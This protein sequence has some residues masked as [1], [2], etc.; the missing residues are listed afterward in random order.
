MWACLNLSFMA[1]LQ[2]DFRWLITEPSLID[3][4]PGCP[5]LPSYIS[6]RFR[7][8]YSCQSSHSIPPHCAKERSWPPP[9]TKHQLSLNYNV[10]D[11]NQTR[12]FR[13]KFFLGSLRQIYQTVAK[14]Y[15]SLR[16]SNTQSDWTIPET[17][18]G[19]SKTWLSRAEFRQDWIGE[20]T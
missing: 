10:S 7:A 18:S 5:P 2:A 13:P 17:W 12:Y 16:G 20:M 9:L 8:H 14:V 3:L 1:M 4:L 19:H 15:A 11:T 6:W